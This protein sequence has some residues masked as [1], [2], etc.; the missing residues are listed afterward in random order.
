[1]IGLCEH[2]AHCGSNIVAD[3]RLHNPGVFLVLQRGMLLV[4][5]GGAIGLIVALNLSTL[6]QKLLFQVHALDASVFSIATL[7]LL[8]VSIVGCYLPARRASRADPMHALR[9]L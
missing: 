8:F 9:C 4:V 6:I 5:A 7:L 3:A 2:I 1:M